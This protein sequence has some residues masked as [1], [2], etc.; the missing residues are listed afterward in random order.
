MEVCEIGREKRAL[1]VEEDSVGEYGVAEDD[2]LIVESEFCPDG[3]PSSP[4]TQLASPTPIVLLD[5]SSSK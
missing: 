5:D 1:L 4:T 2:G 3:A